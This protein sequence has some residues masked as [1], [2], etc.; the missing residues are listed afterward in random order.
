MAVHLA[1]TQI[2]AS[3]RSAVAAHSKKAPRAS[4]CDA[5]MQDTVAWGP[6]VLIAQLAIVSRG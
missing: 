5:Q 3:S 6:K 1:A 2:L 4:G